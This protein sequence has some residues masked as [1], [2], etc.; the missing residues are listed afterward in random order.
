MAIETYEDINTFAEENFPEAFHNLPNPSRLVIKDYG[1]DTWRVQ[2]GVFFPKGQEEWIE[3]KSR[4]NKHVGDFCLRYLEATD[5]CDGGEVWLAPGDMSYAKVNERAGIPTTSCSIEQTRNSFDAFVRYCMLA[6]GFSVDLE[7]RCYDFME[8]FR[9]A[10][11]IIHKNSRTASGSIA[12]TESSEDDAGKA[13]SQRLLKNAVELV[14]DEMQQ[15]EL[16]RYELQKSLKERQAELDRAQK[17]SSNKTEQLK[18]KDEQLYSLK[19]C[20]RIK[21]TS[22]TAKIKS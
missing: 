13:S 19:S 11:E 20:S 18:L 17:D 3:I 12:S 16:R 15:H 21:A 10:C 8:A 7:G 6:Q 5:I 4:E 14:A 22:W 9:T 1:S 2:L